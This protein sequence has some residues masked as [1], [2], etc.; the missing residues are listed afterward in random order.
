MGETRRLTPGASVTSCCVRARA[1]VCV[2]ACV[3]V[4]VRARAQRGCLKSCFSRPRRSESPWRGSGCEATSVPGFRA[5]P[6]GP[7][8]RPAGTPPPNP[9]T[10]EPAPAEQA[11]GSHAA[12]A[13]AALGAK[14]P[15]SP[16]AATFALRSRSSSGASWSRC[17]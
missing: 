14:R 10:P 5:H 12:A 11:T 15:G 9:R 2:P 13:G 6:G 4:H 3:C 17:T 7:P 1:C 16:G 8:C